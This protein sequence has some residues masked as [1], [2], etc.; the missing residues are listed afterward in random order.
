LSSNLIVVAADEA[1]MGEVDPLAPGTR[2]GDGGPV[3]FLNGLDDAVPPVEPPLAHPATT[4]ASA[5][6]HN[7]R[8]VFIDI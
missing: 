1:A 5:M 7:S 8:L 3:E 4:T 6:A 2:L